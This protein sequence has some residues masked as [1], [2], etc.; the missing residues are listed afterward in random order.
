MRSAS[1]TSQF[2][3]AGTAL[4]TLSPPK[5]VAL[6]LPIWGN[7]HAERALKY[8]LP[9]LLAR[10]N[11]PC[12]AT[13]FRCQLVIATEERLFDPLK[14]SEI[15]GAFESI[16]GPCQFVAIDDL[17]IGPGSYGFTL[18]M[19]LFRA[20]KKFGRAM[21]DTSFL[22]V[23]ADFII[24]NNSYRSLI[25]HLMAGEQIIC[26]P[27]YC[28]IEEQ[29]IPTLEARRAGQMSLEISKRQ[30]ADLILQTLHST[31]RGQKIDGS[32]HY[33]SVYLYQSYIQ[34]D[35]ETLL[36]HQMPICVVA[37]RPAICI[38]EIR[39][40]W[41]WGVVSELCP[42]GKEAVLGDSDDFLI[43]E[44][45]KAKTAKDLRRP[46]PM[47]PEFVASRLASSISRDQLH[48]GTFPL[49][50][51]SRDLPPQLDKSWAAMRRYQR[52]LFTRLP[53]NATDHKDHPNWNT[54]DR[55]Y[56][57]KWG[58]APPKKA[59]EIKMSINASWLRMFLEM[60]RRLKFDGTSAIALGVQ[61]VMFNHSTAEDLLFE[62][63]VP[64][65][66]IPSNARTYSLSRN[67]LQFT[68]DPR[69]YMGAKDLFKMIGYETIDTLDAFENDR[70]D[71]LWNL[72]E[73]IPDEWRNRYDLLFDI[74][75]LEHTSNI[76]QA[77]ENVGNLVKVDGWIALYLPMVSPINSCMYHPNPPFYFDIL[78]ANGFD[79][80]LAWINWMPD[81]DQRNDI[82]TI[83]QNFQ[84]NDDVHIYRPRFYT[85]MF[86]LAQKRQHV[87]KFRPVL[88]N[89][90]MDWHAG[91]KLFGGTAKHPTFGGGIGLSD[92][93]AIYGARAKRDAFAREVIASLENEELNGTKFVYPTVM[94]EPTP[95]QLRRFPLSELGV[96]HSP[97]SVVAPVDS[98]MQDDIPEQMT[99]GSPPREQLYL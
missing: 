34:H 51:H 5:S 63:E 45:R 84:Y 21:T 48:F 93:A 40:F 50:L 37:I 2:G 39:S 13:A 56:R 35:A 69:Y 57:Q 7:E 38:E 43:L 44:L 71:L 47:T 92:T 22:C 61:D 98:R 4:A 10:G 28:T 55:I 52:Q 80:F 76:F 1:S 15:I 59:K 24:A 12:L 11:F 42:N 83:W 27:T 82:R 41:D 73:P 25:P 23:N 90:Y 17:L 26:S 54:H 30:M 9:A 64:F 3:V 6:V 53:P 72:C 78:A 29:V 19:A 20:V 86:F 74:G 62:R 31:V 87:K 89:Y 81:W 75:V 91:T 46:G 36:G 99:V 66:R 65:N 68:R 77:L 96:P 32:F 14:R 67:Q 97:D 60:R 33:D 58:L 16:A 94:S 49:T 79:N 8:M 18:T 85:I 88:Q 95:A 70:P